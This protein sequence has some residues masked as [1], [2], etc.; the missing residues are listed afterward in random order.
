MFYFLILREKFAQQPIVMANVLAVLFEI[1]W[2]L[3]S[4]DNHKAARQLMLLLQWNEI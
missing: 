4:E 1:V 2:L 3:E